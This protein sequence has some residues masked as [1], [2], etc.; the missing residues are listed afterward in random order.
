[1]QQFSPLPLLVDRGAPQS[2]LRVATRS[3]KQ[4]VAVQA[5][6]TTSRTSTM[7]TVTPSGTAD[8]TISLAVL[9]ASSDSQTDI[10]SPPLPF[11]VQ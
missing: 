9:A 6:A 5:L 4:P 3:A 11:L 7:S 2:R 8:L 1:V 10:D